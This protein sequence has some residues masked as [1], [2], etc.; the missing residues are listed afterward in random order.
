M[1]VPPKVAHD[2]TL[3][4]GARINPPGSY[5]TVQGGRKR[6]SVLGL[7]SSKRHARRSARGLN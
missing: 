3:K 4:S 1:R 5:T 7:V 2:D 6:R